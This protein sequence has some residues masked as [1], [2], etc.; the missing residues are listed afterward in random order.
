MYTCMDS[1]RESIWILDSILLDQIAFISHSTK[2]DKLK[3]KLHILTTGGFRSVSVQSDCGIQTQLWA[4]SINRPLTWSAFSATVPWGSGWPRSFLPLATM[5]QLPENSDPDGWMNP[6]LNIEFM[7]WM[8]LAD[9]SDLLFQR[10]TL[11][12]SRFDLEAHEQCE[13]DHL[14]IYDGPSRGSP[15]LG[16]YCGSRWL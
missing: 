8:L 15:I 1:F 12:F 2:L 13:Y 16:K 9:T 10:L 6:I 7:Y 14:S 11:V 4:N 3:R 5:K